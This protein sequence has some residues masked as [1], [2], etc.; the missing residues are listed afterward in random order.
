MYEH[1]GQ[2]ADAALAS[3]RDSAHIACHRKSATGSRRHL[4]TPPQSPLHTGVPVE[5]PAIATSGA[6]PRAHRSPSGLDPGQP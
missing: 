6:F 5:G 3:N 4:P 2:H 1:D